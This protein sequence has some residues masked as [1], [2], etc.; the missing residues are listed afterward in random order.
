[1]LR[2]TIELWHNCCAHSRLRSTLQNVTICKLAI[3]TQKSRKGYENLM[4]L[5][6]N[7][8][9]VPGERTWEIFIHNKLGT[10]KSII[11]PD[12]HKSIRLPLESYK[13]TRVYLFFMHRHLPLS[14]LASSSL[15]M[16][17]CTKLQSL[18]I[19]FYNTNFIQIM[20]WSWLLDA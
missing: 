17:Q 9:Y 10:K 2:P 15:F 5:S 16:L 4:W 11:S 7:L 12:S 3:S 13:I 8:T 1:M 19:E 6:L 18:F 20:R 14:F